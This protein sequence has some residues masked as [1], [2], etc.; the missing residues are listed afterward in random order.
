MDKE[1]KRDNREFLVVG[2]DLRAELLMKSS[3]EKIE[4]VEPVIEAKLGDVPARVQLHSDHVGPEDTA[5]QRLARE[6]PHESDA[7]LCQKHPRNLA[8]RPSAEA[9]A[10]FNQPDAVFVERALG[11]DGELR[12]AS[13]HG[14]Y[15]PS[16]LEAPMSRRRDEPES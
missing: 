14:H 16:S 7:R 10:G 15:P 2:W 6:R 4:V 5:A 1:K 12:R 9:Q 11:G 8:S 13:M 3:M